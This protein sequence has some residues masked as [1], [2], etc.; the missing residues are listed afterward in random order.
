MFKK[1][2][3]VKI[4]AVILAAAIAMPSAVTAFAAGR[5]AVGQET[6]ES[7]GIWWSNLLHGLYT[8]GKGKDESTKTST[9]T[10]TATSPGEDSLHVVKLEIKGLASFTYGESLEEKFT[11]EARYGKDGK[12]YSEGDP[13][14]EFSEDDYRLL[15]YNEQG[16]ELK[17]APKDAGKYTVKAFSVEKSRFKSEGAAKEFEIAK[18][19]ITIKPA[20]RTVSLDEA[21]NLELSNWKVDLANGSE[22]AY[23]EEL[24]ENYTLK[25]TVNKD[26]KEIDSIS[27]AGEYDLVI[28]SSKLQL[29]LANGA[30]A[31]NYSVTTEK[32]TLTVGKKLE[33]SL[34]F[35]E[36]R[37]D[38]EYGAFDK[39]GLL[40][41]VFEGD[42]YRFVVT[43]GYKGE[44]VNLDD[45]KSRL[46]FHY[47]YD[48]KK[49]KE[50]TDE[51][52]LRKVNNYW[53]AAKFDF[54]EKDGYWGESDPEAFKIT[55]RPI[56]VKPKDRT[57]EN[58]AELPA[59]ESLDVTIDETEKD[60]FKLRYDDKWNIEPSAQIKDRDKIDTK[61]SGNYDIIA[62]A[63]LEADCADNY[64]L[65]KG[66]GVLTVKP[67]EGEEKK[68]LKLQ[69]A[70][71]SVVYG[72][73]G[74][75]DPAE[76][77]RKA[78]IE[79]I[80]ATEAEGGREVSLKEDNIVLRYYDSEEK[81]LETPPVDV[82]EKGYYVT[83]AYE[84]DEAYKECDATEP[85]ELKITERTITIEAES[86]KI[87]NGAELP[88]AK[89]KEAYVL[90]YE[91]K[92]AEDGE[93]K[94][95]Y[96]DKID[97]KTGGDYEIL[98]S[99]KVEDD[100]ANNYKLDLI[101]GTLTV[102]KL[103]ENG[104]SLD[105][106]SIKEGVLTEKVYDGKAFDLITKD[107][108]VSAFGYTG[109]YDYMWSGADGEALESAPT[110]A[111]KYTLTV[112]IPDTDPVWEG[113]TGAVSI[114]IK[115][116][117]ITA[118]AVVKSGK[119]E[120]Y[121]GEILKFDVEI[122][123]K[124]AFV[125]DDKWIKEPVAKIIEGD[126]NKAGSYKVQAADGD[127]GANY[128]VVYGA[129]VEITVLG[130]KKPLITT[131]DVK[132]PKKGY[133][134]TGEQ[135]CPTVTAKCGKSKLKLNVDYVVD[136]S[137]NVNAGEA[138]VTVRGIGEYAGYFTKQFTIGKKDIKKVTLSEVGTV[139]MGDDLEANLRGIL[140]VMDGT[141]E[142]SSDDYEILVAT[143]KGGEFVSLSKVSC[144]DSEILEKAELK[145]QAVNKEGN[146]YTGISSKK[147]KL[148][149]LG[150]DVQAESITKV[151]FD[152]SCLKIPAKGYTYNGK[153]Q[154]PKVKINGVKTSEFKVVYSN[155]VNAGK[156]TVR[157]VGVYNKK[158]G[159]GY[160]GV[161]SPVTFDIQ[162]KSLN[163]VKASAGTAVP[164]N[165]TRDDIKLTVKDGKH[166]L[167]EGVDY[168]AMFDNIL[169]EN[170]RIKPAV[171]AKSKNT[172][173]IVSLGGN[174][175]A[176]TSK[177]VTIKFGQLNLASKNAK[178]NVSM[179]SSSES[180]V[181]V[182][183][184]GVELVQG[185]DYTV[186]KLKQN[187]DGSYTVTIKAAKDKK[188]VY[189]G[190]KTV[191]NVKVEAVTGQ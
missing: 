65:E 80:T 146:N 91:D 171:E 73:G 72:D 122:M 108:V 25:C 161:S 106:L 127:A 101:N 102:A 190:S 174:Y 177:D 24:A 89:L 79:N 60:E 85:A 152:Q 142:V 6:E 183:Y 163:R 53:A 168:K 186:S 114:E 120:A 29:K 169:D 170:G 100:K 15:Y 149:I 112:K 48:E 172:V 113:S 7:E 110:D 88:A 181:K 71:V 82:D 153:A 84:G 105:E 167:T 138:A 103:G 139:K 134:Y 121:A 148:V 159:T 154:K 76:N 8:M 124:E 34:Q 136:Y 187:K 33:L 27:E 92:W 10:D 62:V 13:V 104:K 182:V 123:E 125:G 140:V 18:K 107:S 14:T 68:E 188:C 175:Q 119:N 111:G 155:N 151:T 86:E 115:Q 69:L 189:K 131:V 81:A 54:D 66:K 4:M 176:G 145:V 97:T 166:I 98:V 128:D 46:S 90:C 39:N 165:G 144:G 57:L 184:N 156:G 12:E 2:T 43:A 41:N 164:K 75:K 96:K 67:A 185:T 118:Q 45:K 160:Y 179:T 26:G 129:A 147:A 78:V 11:V 16:A 74:S 30:K 117:T 49:E 178:V 42:F 5:E 116:R 19:E 36:D 137:N 21:E 17:E 93:P 51:K 132:I 20:D 23:E 141:Y 22:L 157:I 150:K 162:Q 55:Q 37:K 3:G 77:L 9:S 173:K 28:D 58:G 191:K 40:G 31:E 44:T 158:K 95:A 135:I 1:K 64:A 143:K 130:E 56:T 133:I 87:A 47:Y 83:A 99:A 32:G 50:I 63:E 180:G 38:F 35:R 109:E 94:A 59:D 126:V 70:A 52:E 61:V